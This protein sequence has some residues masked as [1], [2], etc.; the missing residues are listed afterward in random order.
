M[1]PDT[2]PNIFQAPDLKEPPS[3][4]LRPFLRRPVFW[5][6]FAAAGALLILVL[7][8]LPLMIRDSGPVARRTQSKINLRQMGLALQNYHETFG[9]FP[10]GTVSVPE[11]PVEQRFSWILPLI[12]FTDQPL[13]TKVRAEAGWQSAEHAELINTAQIIYCN[14]EQRLERPFRSGGDYVAIAG[15]GADAAELPENHPRTGVFGY[16]RRST[17][18]SITDGLSNTLMIT[19]LVQP[20]RSMFAGGRET[21]R[22]F[23]HQPYLN[24][25]DGIGAVAGTNAVQILLADGSVRSLALTTDAQLIEA[26]ATKAGGDRVPDSAEW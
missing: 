23:S 13:R 25:P 9:M 21:V 2:E 8:A 12:P 17:L 15:I 3:E 6:S 22:G 26:L 11:L 18:E 19:T 4:K 1:V 20:N 7:A 14:P 24:G 16:D 5:I 10:A